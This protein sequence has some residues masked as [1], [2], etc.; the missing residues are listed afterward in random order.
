MDM[1]GLTSTSMECLYSTRATHVTH[2]AILELDA[3]LEAELVFHGVAA[4]AKEV[5]QY[6]GHV[7]GALGVQK[8]TA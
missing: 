8:R 3:P 5:L 1:Q 7:H 4:Q 2:S 6:C